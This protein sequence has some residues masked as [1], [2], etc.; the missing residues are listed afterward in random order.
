MT[1]SMDVLQAN[2]EDG[3]RPSSSGMVHEKVSSLSPHRIVAM[4]NSPNQR[5]NQVGYEQHS[6]NP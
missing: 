3:I 1:R 5:I 2:S 4:K 6:R